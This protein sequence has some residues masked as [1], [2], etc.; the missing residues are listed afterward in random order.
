MM[1][2]MMVLLDTAG[3]VLPPGLAF[4]RPGWWLLHLLAILFV[5]YYGYRKGRGEERR[6]RRAREL[7]GKAPSREDSGGR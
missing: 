3:T 6:A 7:E 2:T 1:M 5:Y 4:L